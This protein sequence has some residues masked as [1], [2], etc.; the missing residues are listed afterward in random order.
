MSHIT[1]QM[2]ALVAIDELALALPQFYQV[3]FFA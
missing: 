1:A 2:R 3:P